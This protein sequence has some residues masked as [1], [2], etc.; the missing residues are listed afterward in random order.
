MVRMMMVLAAMA[1][2]S[3]VRWGWRS[4]LWENRRGEL[5]WKTFIKLNLFVQWMLKEFGHPAARSGRIPARMPCQASIGEQRGRPGL[6]PVEGTSWV[7]VV[8]HLPTRNKTHFRRRLPL[9]WPKES[10][11]PPY[12]LRYLPLLT[13]PPPSAHLLFAYRFL[14]WSGRL[15]SVESLSPCVFISCFSLYL[16]RSLRKCTCFETWKDHC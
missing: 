3:Q 7:F 5:S 16:C 11:Y 6:G 15:D 13:V 8:I 14:L 4:W 12:F 2:E 1:E 10:Y 9:T